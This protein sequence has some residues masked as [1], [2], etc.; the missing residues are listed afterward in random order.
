MCH[1]VGKLLSRSKQVA[2]ETAL[3]VTI[4]PTVVVLAVKC[5]P[6]LSEP[7]PCLCQLLSLDLGCTG[8]QKAA[9]FGV[10]PMASTRWQG[11]GLHGLQE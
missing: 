5:T 6:H 11:T 9:R 8:H 7:G 10:S 1:L 3:R 2:L 4:N